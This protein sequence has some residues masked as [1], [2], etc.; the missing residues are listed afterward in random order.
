MYEYSMNEITS[1]LVRIQQ[2]FIQRCKFTHIKAFD[3][4]KV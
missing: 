3:N 4:G 2:D 1:S